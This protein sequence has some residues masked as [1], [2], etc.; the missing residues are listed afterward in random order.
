MIAVALLLRLG[1]H[2]TDGPVPIGDLRTVGG[3]HHFILGT[4]NG[5]TKGMKETRG[6]QRS[7][8]A[9]R[10]LFVFLVSPLI[11]LFG[12]A[13][14]RGEG[15]EAEGVELDEALSVLLV[16]GAAVVLEG[17]EVLRV[18]RIGRRAAG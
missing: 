14:A 4:S 8:C 13:F 5:D 6:S 15:A 17:D 16:V 9:L 12:F 10:A 7:A 18:E 1:P 11:W 2:V 3:S